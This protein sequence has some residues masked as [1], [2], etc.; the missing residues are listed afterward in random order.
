MARWCLCPR[1]GLFPHT[2]PTPAA[3]L[4]GDVSRRPHTAHCAKDVGLVC[5]F[6]RVSPMM[7][8]R[9]KVDTGRCG[10]LRPTYGH[11]YS[12]NGPAGASSS[13]ILSAIM[14]Q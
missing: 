2:G 3:M 13:C 4:A 7:V 14:A 11:V 8:I 5:F 1:P 9:S 10:H 12:I 6:V